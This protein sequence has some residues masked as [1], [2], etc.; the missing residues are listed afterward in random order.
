VAPKSHKTRA[1]VLIPVHRQTGGLSHMGGPGRAGPALTGFFVEPFPIDFW[2]LKRS[3]ALSAPSSPFLGAQSLRRLSKQGRHL[4]PYQSYACLAIITFFVIPSPTQ[5]AS[6]NEDA[7]RCSSTRCF[8][9]VLSG[10][11]IVAIV[12]AARGRHSRWE[13]PEIPGRIVFFI[14]AVGRSPPSFMSS[15]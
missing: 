4:S 9:Q 7:K 8:Y 3:F 10:L 12:H 11:L 14:T 2:K 13:S 15:K 1:R 5:A 6:L